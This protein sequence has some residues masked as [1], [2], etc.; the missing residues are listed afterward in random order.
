MR[1]E[2]K[3]DKWN[4]DRG[5]G[6]ITPSRGGEPV[7]VHI[8]AFPH[9]GR[10][11]MPGE[12]LTFEV[13][14]T[15]DGKKR[16]TKVERPNS[17]PRVQAASPPEQRRHRSSNRRG[18]G[19]SIGGIA[20]AAAA[21]VFGGGL[22]YSQFSGLL[23]RHGSSPEGSPPPATTWQGSSSPRF[24][25]DGRIH[26][27]QMTSCDEAKFFLRNC[28]G[29]QMDGDGDGVPCEKQWCSGPFGR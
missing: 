11:P 14:P 23:N 21:T 13:E 17:R 8:S 1:F 19:W 16:A 18:S 7:F 2:G 26:C 28:P 15:G 5:F 10:R 25:C 24:Q 12:A 4:D 29:T 9:D 6:F 20:L 22:L 27:S 3:L